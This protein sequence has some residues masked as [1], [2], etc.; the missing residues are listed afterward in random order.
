MIK[1]ICDICGNEVPSL[2]PEPRF[3][4]SSRGR[5]MDIC[6]KCQNEFMQWIMSRNITS[7]IVNDSGT[8]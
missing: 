6:P 8:E 5:K 2:G 3:E 1:R 4:I 7:P